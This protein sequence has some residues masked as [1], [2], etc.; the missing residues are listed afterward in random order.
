M[1]SDWLDSWV[2]QRQIVDAVSQRAGNHLQNQTGMF[3]CILTLC[4]FIKSRGFFLMSC[5]PVIFPPMC[6]ISFN[7]ALY[8]TYLIFSY[9]MLLCSALGAASG[10][11]LGT[12]SWGPF[13]LAGSLSIGVRELQVPVWTAPK[14]AFFLDPQCPAMS[15]C[16][17]WWECV[18]I[19]GGWGGRVFSLFLTVENCI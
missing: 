16:C 7:C 10:P 19:Y 13:G 1:S 2:G 5:I 8:F 17:Q 18:C 15:P 9:I 3:I 11:L 6:Q 12:L 14:V 4:S